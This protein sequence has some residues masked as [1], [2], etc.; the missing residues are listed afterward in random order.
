MTDDKLLQNELAARKMAHNCPV[1]SSTKETLGEQCFKATKS[2][3]TSAACGE[4][5]MALRR[6]VNTLGLTPLEI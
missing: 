1:Y 5:W 4:R 2:S 3:A 6:Q